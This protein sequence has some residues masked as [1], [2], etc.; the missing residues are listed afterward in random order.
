MEDR[1]RLYLEGD[2]V[3]PGRVYRLDNRPAVSSDKI[4]IKQ[5]RLV[6][7]FASS[8]GDTLN[9]KVKKRK[10]KTKIR[11]FISKELESI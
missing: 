3:Q 8:T 11:W 4:Y 5:K 6:G 2:F 9:K 7:S 10:N 1:N